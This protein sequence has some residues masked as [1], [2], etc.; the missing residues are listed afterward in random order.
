MGY[1]YEVKAWME[2]EGEYEY[3]MQYQ[4]NSMA[5]AIEAAIEAKKES[6]CVNIIWRG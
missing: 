5:E 3:I 2:I 6:G 1:K 4:G